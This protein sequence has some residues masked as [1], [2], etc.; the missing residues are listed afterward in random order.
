MKLPEHNQYRVSV[1]I[2][3]YNSAAYIGRAIR[4][5]RCQTYPAHEIIVVDD[6]STDDTESAVSEFA[7]EVRYIRQSNTGVS[8]A[9]NNGIHAAEGEWIA[10]LDADDEWLPSKLQRQVELLQ[11]HPDLYWVYANFYQC[12]CAGPPRRI[13]HVREVTGKLTE[14]TDYFDSYLSASLSGFYMWTGTVLVRRQALLD[15]GLFQVGMFK[16]EDNDMWY[17]LSYRWSKVGYILEPLSVYH[18]CNPACATRT[19]NQ[20]SHMCRLVERNLKISAQHGRYKE[21][22]PVASMTLEIWMRE[23]LAENRMGEI[24]YLLVRFGYLL[25][26]RFRGE[27]WLRCTFG[28]LGN[29]LVNLVWFFTKKHQKKKTAWQ[30]K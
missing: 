30:M 27:M 21:F 7:G 26:I 4:S 15:A 16:G 13:A 14:D 17:R 11:R 28:Y 6:G 12:G 2:P 1:V 22:L 25:P 18:V 20:T 3:T 29:R 23:I 19:C 9:R 8:S 24:R 5:V 10:F